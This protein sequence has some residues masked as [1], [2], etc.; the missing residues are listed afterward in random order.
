MADVSLT[1]T[2]ASSL[3]VFDSSGLVGQSPLKG[4]HSLF[5]RLLNTQVS[6]F[7]FSTG[8]F[9]LWFFQGGFLFFFSIFL[10]V[11]PLFF[12]F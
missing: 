3:S 12:I 8:W 4:W 7:L 10:F 9:S 2:P 5:Y 6:V 1:R 11:F